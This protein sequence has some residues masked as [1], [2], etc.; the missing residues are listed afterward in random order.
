MVVSLRVAGESVNG[1]RRG[2][3]AER[4]T[5]NDVDRASLPHLPWTRNTCTPKATAQF[6]IDKLQFEAV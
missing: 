6:K 1:R 3:R 4:D 2:C 5:A